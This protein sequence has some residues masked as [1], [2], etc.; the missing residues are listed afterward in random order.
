[1][2]HPQDRRQSPGELLLEFSSVKESGRTVLLFATEWLLF[3]YSEAFD[4]ERDALFSSPDLLSSLSWPSFLL[5]AGLNGLFL[6]PSSTALLPVVCCLRALLG[7][8]ALIATTTWAELFSSPPSRTDPTPPEWTVNCARASPSSLLPHL[9]GPATDRPA[10]SLLF[11][12][13]WKST[14]GKN[15]IS[16]EH[17]CDS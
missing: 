17:M 5:P 12:S 11:P 7:T 10:A 2:P 6:P 3:P 16:G 4:A 15:Y 14:G 9:H 1:M 8:A 13:P